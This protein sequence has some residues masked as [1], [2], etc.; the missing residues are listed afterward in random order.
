MS[1]PA[2]ITQPG[3]E[4]E[5]DRLGF[6]H[7][8]IVRG[9]WSGCPCWLADAPLPEVAVVEAVV[10]ALPDPLPVLEW[11]RDQVAVG[12]TRPA[13]L[14]APIDDG[15]GFAL[16]PVQG[17]DL[18]VDPNFVAHIA[19]TLTGGEWRLTEPYENPDSG[20]SVPLLVWVVDGAARGMIM[21][22]RRAG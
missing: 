17:A 15:D 10:K 9:A 19:R 13:V 1:V 11:V 14:L 20:I 5:F 22:R 6:W 16:L 7:Y 8:G 4:S 21:P 2:F 3:E 12:A 18:A